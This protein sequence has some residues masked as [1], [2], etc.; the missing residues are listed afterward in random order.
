MKL[1][2]TDIGLKNRNLDVMNIYRDSFV[3]Y[4]EKKQKE[5]GQHGGIQ[6]SISSDGGFNVN[7][8]RMKGKLDIFGI[9]KFKSI[10]QNLSNDFNS[11]LFDTGLLLFIS[12][13]FF[14]LAMV[15]FLKYDV[16]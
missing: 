10:K 16:R 9:P 7:T 8:P 4:I 1:A 14:M 2:G 15:S 6:I 5:S 12:T 11:I 3:N 13:I